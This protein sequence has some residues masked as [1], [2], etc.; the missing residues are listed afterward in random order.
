MLDKVGFCCDTITT[1]VWNHQSISEFTLSSQCLLR[2]GVQE[3]LPHLSFDTPAYKAVQTSPIH[4]FRISVIRTMCF[5][6]MLMEKSLVFASDAV[7]FILD[8]LQEY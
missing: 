8:F 2:F 6:F 4:S 7:Q 3:F 5:H 1:I